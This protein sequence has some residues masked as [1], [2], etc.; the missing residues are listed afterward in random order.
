MVYMDLEWIKMLCKDATI[1]VTQHILVRCQQR[2]IS[3]KEI[4]EEYP[5][6]SC[7]ILGTTIKGRRMHA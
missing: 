6:P 3:Y 7:L 1:E 2:D 5:Y 4:I